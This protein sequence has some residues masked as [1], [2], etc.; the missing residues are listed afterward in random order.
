MIITYRKEA[1]A[2][3]RDKRKEDKQYQQ[4]ERCI[5][6]VWKQCT[7]CKEMG[8]LTWK[9]PRFQQKKML[10]MEEKDTLVME[11]EGLSDWQ[12]HNSLSF[13]PRES[14][15][16]AKTGGKSIKFLM[17]MDTNIHVVFQLV[18]PLLGKKTNVKEVIS[19]TSTLSFYGSWQVLFRKQIWF[20]CAHAWLSFSPPGL[21]SLKAASSDFTY[22]FR[23]H[24]E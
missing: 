1:K 15:L 6:L 18:V 7:Y 24:F 21:R 23:N 10:V 22:S 19:P 3:T 16:T 13:S 9:F 11:T 2:G 20:P 12:V 4:R 17:D 5:P 8:N 14:I